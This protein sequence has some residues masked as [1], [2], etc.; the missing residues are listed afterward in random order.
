[1]ANIAEGGGRARPEGE[2]VAAW[3]EVTARRREAPETQL[4]EALGQLEQVV[5]MLVA[6]IESCDR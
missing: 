3:L 4:N 5:A 1:V 2:G 6:L